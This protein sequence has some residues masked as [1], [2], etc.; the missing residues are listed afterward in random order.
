ML[1]LSAHSPGWLHPKCNSHEFLNLLFYLRGIPRPEVQAL[2][3][4][5]LVDAQICSPSSLLIWGLNQL[6]EAAPGSVQQILLFGKM[7]EE[8]PTELQVLSQ[9]G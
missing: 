9:A 8:M 5:V 2:G 3:L 1:L 4:T 6:Q 7:P